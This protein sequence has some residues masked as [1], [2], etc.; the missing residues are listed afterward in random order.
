MIEVSGV[1]N[2]CETVET[3][4][5]LAARASTSPVTSLNTTTA[6]RK[7]PASSFSGRAPVE[8]TRLPGAS[9]KQTR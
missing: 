3:T 8:T 1:R 5:S 2:S 4:S 9:P 7:S 6:P